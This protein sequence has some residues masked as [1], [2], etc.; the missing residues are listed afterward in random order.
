MVSG[1]SKKEIHPVLMK[2]EAAFAHLYETP[3]Q[4]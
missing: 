3:W 4:T 1:F 2:Q